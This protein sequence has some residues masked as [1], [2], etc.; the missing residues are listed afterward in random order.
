VSAK[1][2]GT[3]REQSMTITGGS[4]LGKDDIERMM[5]DAEAHAED[6]RQRRDEADVR[7]Q[8]DQLV[9]Q[10]ERFLADNA[11]KVP[12]EAKSNVEGPLAELKKLLEG[13]DTEA[14][15]AGIEKVAT[16]SQALGAAMYQESQ[17]AAGA[18]AP[19]ADAN[20]AA[21]DDVV[22]AEVVDEGS[23][24]PSEQDR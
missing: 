7:N 3:G 14:I 18:E 22:D 21:D 13:T 6:D 4:A 19:A 17:A 9:Y 1:D 5:R 8:A 10:T 23:D 15:K 12:A 20:D 24:T 2:L 16:A 11:D